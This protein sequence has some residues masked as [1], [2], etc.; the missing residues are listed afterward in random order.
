MFKRSHALR[1]ESYQ[2]RCM[3]LVIHFSLELHVCSLPLAS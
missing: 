2:E 1:K 3:L